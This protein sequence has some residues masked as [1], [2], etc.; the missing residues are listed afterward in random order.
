MPTFRKTR[1]NDWS[2]GEPSGF[3]LSLAGA[4]R[5]LGRRDAAGALE[6]LDNLATGIAADP[7]KLGQV[8]AMVGDC[9]SMQGRY[10]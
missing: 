2:V 9:E 10:G 1:Q 3:S 4:N 6:A 7:Q 5:M 8:L